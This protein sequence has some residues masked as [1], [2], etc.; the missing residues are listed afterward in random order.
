MISIYQLTKQWI[1]TIILLLRDLRVKLDVINQF[2]QFEHQ[3]N[4]ENQTFTTMVK[5]LKLLH[6]MENY[7]RIVQGYVFLYYF[8]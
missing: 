8:W 1:Y 5:T 7:I 4:D 2:K 6:Q 3:F